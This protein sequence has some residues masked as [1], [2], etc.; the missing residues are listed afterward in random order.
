M[1]VQSSPSAARIS[2][3]E[4]TGQVAADTLLPQATVAVHARP[5]LLFSCLITRMYVLCRSKNKYLLNN[6]LQIQV[7]VGIRLRQDRMH[8]HVNSTI[9]KLNTEIIPSFI[10]QS[11]CRH[12]VTKQV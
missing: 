2:C 4:Q 11:E 7:H 10:V 5:L 12:Y 9:V 8:R 6:A 3:S 1:E